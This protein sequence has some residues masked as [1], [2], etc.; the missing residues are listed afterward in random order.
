[1]TISLRTGTSMQFLYELSI[2]ELDRVTEEI[3]NVNK[4]K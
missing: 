1:M 3:L 2:D 4:K